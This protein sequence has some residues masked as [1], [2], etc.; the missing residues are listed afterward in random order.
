M[1]MEKQN[2]KKTCCDLI[3]MKKNIYFIL[4]KTKTQNK[5]EEEIKKK[6][7]K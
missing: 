2:K 1:K 4:N 7:K 6:N 3:N 5:Q